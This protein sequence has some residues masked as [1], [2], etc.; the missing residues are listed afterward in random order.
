MPSTTSSGPSPDASPTTP[1][2]A[3][4]A[5]LTFFEYLVVFLLGWVLMTWSYSG[6][7]RPDLGVPGNDS[8][9]HIKMSTM[10]PQA[11]KLRQF[12]WLQFCYFTDQGDDF[13]SHHYG[14]HLLL[15]PFVQLSQYLTGSYLPGAR[16][17][18]AVFFGLL[19]VVLHRLVAHATMAWRWIWL[20]LFTSCPSSFSPDMLSSAQSAPRWPSCS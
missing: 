10:M 7:T 6:L 11:V 5:R 20:P 15:A 19:M 18:V 16:W 14:F 13:V 4:S 3:F 8:F 9:Y 17:G 1:A 2:L 12:P